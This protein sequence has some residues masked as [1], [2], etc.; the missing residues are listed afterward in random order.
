MILSPKNVKKMACVVL[1]MRIVVQKIA[2]RSFYG[3]MGIAKTH[4]HHHYHHHQVLKI[5]GIIIYS[6]QV[7]DMNRV[8]LFKY[9]TQIKVEC[10]NL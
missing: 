5:T 6:V 9:L 7:I 3:L 2:K 8:N 1:K 10:Y 4:S